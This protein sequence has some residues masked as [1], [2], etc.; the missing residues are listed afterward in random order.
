M[1]RAWVAVASVGLGL[2][3]GTAA[4]LA[5][6]PPLPDVLTE[7]SASSWSASADGGTAAVYDDTSRKTVGA[8]SV[9]FET[10]GGFDTW[11]W[12]PTAMDAGWDFISAGS[13]GLTFWVYTE[14]TNGGFQGPSPWIHLHRDASN[15]FAYTTNHDF[16]NDALG[17]WVSVYVPFNGDA[18]W[19]RTTYGSPNLNNINYIEIHG[20]TW[21]AGFKMWIDGLRFDQ[22]FAPPQSLVAVAGNSSVALA[23]KAWTDVT[24]QFD[25]YAVYRATSAFTDVTGKTPIGTVSGISYTDNTAVNGTHYYYAVTAVLT[26]GGET[27]KVTSVGPRTPR[28]ETDLQITCI[29]RTPRYPRYWPNY[30][31]YEVTEPSGF[32]PYVFSA[33]TSLGGGQTGSTQRWPNVGDAVTYTATV[34][35]RGTTTWSGT[36]GGTW[37]VD[38]VMV[39]N[40]S[41]AVNLAP[42]GTATFP[43]VRNWDNQ[44]HEVKFT[45]NVPDGR[46][47]N[48]EVAIFTKS[49]PFLTY[50]DKNFVEDFREKSTPS[51]PLAATPDMIDWLQRHA[52]EMNDMFIDAGSVKRVHYDVLSVL[53]DRDPDPSAPSTIYFGVFPF[54]YYGGQWGDPRSPGYYHADVDID[55]GLCHEMAHQLGLID[56]YQLG[57]SPQMNQV[58]SMG[59][60]PVACLMNGCSPFYSE[61]SARAMTYWGDI[62]HGYYGQYLYCI[63][64]QVRLRVLDYYG[65]AL[66]GAT[67]SMYQVCERP[68]VGKVITNQVKA[69][70]V[71]DASGEWTLPN[72]PVNASLVPPTA[73]GVLHDN[74][75]GYVAVVGTNGVLHFKIQKGDFVDYA[76]LDITEVNNAYWQGQTALAVFERQTTIGGGIQNFPPA[77][78]A[79]MNVE[80]WTAWSQDGTTTLAND[81]SRKHNGAGSI[82][83]VT[84][85][86][87]DNY[88]RYPIG[89]MARWDLSSVTNIRFWVYASNPSPVGFQSQSPWVRLGNF[90]SG[91]FQWTPSSDVLNN[92]RNRWYEFVVPVAGN[93]TWSRSTFGAPS[94]SRIN[95]LE[96]HADTWDAGFTLWLD[97]VRV[98]PAPQPTPGDTNCDGIVD[99]DDINPFVLAL[100]GAGGYYAAYP[101]CAY[102]NADCNGDGAVDF[103]D[104]NP[105]VALLVQ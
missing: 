48:N 100:T 51:Y 55:Y 92:A 36:L 57:V 5:A 72:V 56:I 37:R 64:T 98:E 28:N 10:D 75:F 84:T 53:D 59:Y 38:G 14:N 29:A 8:A 2:G 105:F 69:Q 27:K 58:S 74:P 35:N 65:A 93:A 47:T 79:E 87:F 44:W 73:A 20:D 62:V 52:K 32:G 78:M 11:M 45:I 31:Y 9:R 99:F 33:A 91:Y 77:D 41:Q 67:V 42:G 66:S 102:E 40:P 101:D 25:H 12:S 90:Q 43:Y 60:S 70:G 4:A 39:S 97:G 46:S 6:N 18:T 104:I 88:V 94:L 54:R 86:G 83:F 95:Y 26:G 19:T 21:G 22:Q 34:R 68:G 49:A 85:G 23:W 16:L 50:V 76:W 3:W 30:T 13:G 96:I 7:S 61:H 24:G 103:D 81:T 15:Y 71:T 63:P 80:N 17:R 82:K 89:L 1:R